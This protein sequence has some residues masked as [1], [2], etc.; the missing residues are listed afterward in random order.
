MNASFW[1]RRLALL[2][3][4]IATLWL[5]GCGSSTGKD[6]APLV[7]AFAWKM[8]ESHQ[9]TRS[10]IETATDWQPFDGAKTWGFGSAPAWVRYTL[11][12][13]IPGE[14]GPWVVRVQP[15]FLVNLTLHDPAAALTL[16]SGLAA[17]LKDD[18]QNSINFTF[19][20]PALPYERDVY[21]QIHSQQRVRL[22]F[23]D[24]LTLRQANVQNRSEE[25]LLSFL[26]AVS[27][28]FALWA[29]MQWVL[30]R[31]HIMGVFAIKQWMTTVGAMSYYGFTRLLLGSSIQP[32]KL[33]TVEQF[34]YAFMVVTGTWFLLVLF[35]D[36]QPSRTWIKVGQVFLVVVL[37]LPC[38]Q[39]MGLEKTLRVLYQM[40][41]PIGIALLWMTLLSN[42]KSKDPPIPWSFMVGYFLLYSVLN[43]AP[44][45][46]F[47]GWL[48]PNL[49]LIKSN[50]NYL[51]LDGLVMVLVLQL[52]ARNMSQHAQRIAQDNQLIAKELDLAQQGMAFEQQRRSEQSQFLHML[53]HE[54]KTPLSI[55]SLALGNR[56]NREENLA[57]A[58]RAVKDMK[59]IIE[60]CVQSDQLGELQLNPHRKTV[61]V[62]KLVRYLGQITPQLEARLHLTTSDTL[63]VLQTDEQM[64][65]IVLSNLLDNASH[66]SDPLTPVTVTLSPATQDGQAGLSVRVSNTPG[67]AGWPDAQKI[68]SKYYRAS[69]AQRESG[70]GLGL[71]L[72][73]Q[74]AHSLGGALHYQPSN[75]YV[76]FVLWIPL[77]PA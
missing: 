55:V 30:L 7:K 61:D 21:L 45:L 31:E 38:L 54:L 32:D 4:A 64:L 20:I 75:Q 68:F 63:P 36:Y 10:D 22:V 29:S 73:R 53:M 3:T 72:S 37:V 11:R 12:A 59:A 15:A 17:S 41:I 13:A 49:F 43:I 14:T 2:L 70:T 5:A 51:V 71:Y 65:Q 50:L 76:E 46:M 18:A 27:A 69:G 47:L 28:V 57:H 48:K 74:L 1:F 24:V 44:R 40:T 34:I 62:V 56:H 16:H 77:H 66:Y 35:K 26:I 23:T 9:A 52:R 25:W 58:G 19:Q 60:R 67:L 6:S 33:S 39:F 8:D 42:A